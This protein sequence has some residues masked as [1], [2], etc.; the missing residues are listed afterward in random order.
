MWIN[1]SRVWKFG[2][3]L[4]HIPT[5]ELWY[6]V[7]ASSGEDEVNEFSAYWYYKNSLK[8]RYRIKKLKKITSIIFYFTTRPAILLKHLIKKPS[9]IK[10]MVKGI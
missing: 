9:I 7:G 2:Y 3:K 8:V 6:K 4:C 5:A 10:P 1:T